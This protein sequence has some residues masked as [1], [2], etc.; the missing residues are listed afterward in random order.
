MITGNTPVEGR[1]QTGVVNAQAFR[2]EQNGRKVVFYG[3]PGQQVTGTLSG[4]E[5]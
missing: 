4:G 1:W 2:V 5:D 3:K